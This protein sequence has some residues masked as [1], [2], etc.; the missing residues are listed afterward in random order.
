MTTQD[1][2]LV[3]R[4]VSN[5][6]FHCMVSCWSWRLLFWSCPLVC[7]GFGI[8]R[9][10]RCINDDSL[11]FQVH[12]RAAICHVNRWVFFSKQLF[13]EDNHSTQ[14][15]HMTFLTALS[16]CCSLK[17]IVGLKTRFFTVSVTSWVL[18]PSVLVLCTYCH[19]PITVKSSTTW[20]IIV[21]SVLLRIIIRHMLLNV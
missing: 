14:S 21:V 19:G 7:L 13:R 15:L 17:A 6:Y 11:S 20:Y 2:W 1:T 12:P 9:L 18:G 8:F 10:M 4:Q 16:L 3:S 5:Q